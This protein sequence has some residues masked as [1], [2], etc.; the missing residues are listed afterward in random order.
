[1]LPKRERLADG[2]EIKKVLN[3]KKKYFSCPLFYL[4]GN[5]NNFTSSRLAV[6]CSSKLGNAVKRNLIRRRIKRAFASIWRN[7]NKK[8]DVVAVARGRVGLL[9]EYT[10]QFAA[11]LEK[12]PE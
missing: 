3:Q 5:E 1:L 8:H 12:W 9:R 7:N 4:A 2:R 11:A 10:S 6:V